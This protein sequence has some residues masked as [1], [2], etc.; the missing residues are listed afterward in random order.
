MSVERILRHDNADIEKD[1][2]LG[3]GLGTMPMTCMAEEQAR[4]KVAGVGE[5]GEHRGL[6]SLLEECD[7]SD[8]NDVQLACMNCVTCCDPLPISDKNRDKAMRKWDKECKAH[9][10]ALKKSHERYGAHLKGRKKSSGRKGSKL[11]SGDIFSNSVRGCNKRLSLILPMIVMKNDGTMM[12][13][14]AR[15]DGQDEREKENHGRDP[16]QREGE[17][18]GEGGD[19]G[20]R[21]ARRSK[22]KVS[23]NGLYRESRDSVSFSEE[24]G[25]QKSKRKGRHVPTEDLIDILGLL[26]VCPSR[27]R[28]R[29]GLDSLS[30]LLLPLKM[31]NVSI[32]ARVENMGIRKHAVTPAE[33]GDSRRHATAAAAALPP[34]LARRRRATIAPRHN[35]DLLKDEFSDSPEDGPNPFSALLEEKRRHHKK[36]LLHRRGGGERKKSH[37]RSWSWDS[38]FS[39]SFPSLRDL[40]GLTSTTASPFGSSNRLSGI[41]PEQQQQQQQQLQADQKFTSWPGTWGATRHGVS[42]SFLNVCSYMNN[43]IYDKIRKSLQM[44]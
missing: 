11:G 27:L 13:Y 1:L 10:E 4:T 12:Q 15:D 30:S 40:G 42:K 16:H 31:T 44:A 18:D 37:N 32:T 41:E 14:D 20:C 2:D 28:T 7:C 33:E 22:P 25:Q 35:Y 3:L 6:P 29:R 34:Q 38:C 43:G 24:A 21:G 36:S 17:G 19:D 39:S 8:V 23:L 5:G 26:S 9:C